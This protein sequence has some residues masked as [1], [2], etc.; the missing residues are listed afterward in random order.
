M[1]HTDY[2]TFSNLSNEK[3]SGESRKSRVITQVKKKGGGGTG[4]KQ[5]LSKLRIL[6]SINRT[7]E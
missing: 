1:S 4:F 7:F 5:N 6:K 3:K 2:R